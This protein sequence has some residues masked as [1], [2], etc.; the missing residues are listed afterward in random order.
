MP[1]TLLSTRIRSSVC[2]RSAASCPLTAPGEEVA[3]ALGVTDGVAVAVTVGEAVAEVVGTSVGVTLGVGWAVGPGEGVG[4]TSVVVGC[5]VA[6]APASAITASSTSQRRR[7]TGSR[8]YTDQAM[9]VTRVAAFVLG[10][11]LMACNAPVGTTQR[12]IEAQPTTAAVSD[13]APTPMRAE[14]LCVDGTVHMPDAPT[15]LPV[16]NLVEAEAVLLAEVARMTGVDKAALLPSNFGLEE[17]DIWGPGVAWNTE[18]VGVQGLQE[19][20]QFYIDLYSGQVLS[21]IDYQSCW[22]GLLALGGPFEIVTPAPSFS[23]GPG[24]LGVAPDKPYVDTPIDPVYAGDNFRPPEDPPFDEP[25]LADIYARVSPLITTVNGLPYVEIRSDFYCSEVDCH[26]QLLAWL[27]NAADPDEWWIGIGRDGSKNEL[28]RNDVWP[29]QYR[30]V[31]HDAAEELLQIVAS[32]P[33]AVALAG[34]YTGFAFASWYPNQLGLMSVSYYRP[35]GL[36][37]GPPI[38]N[39]TTHYL[40]IKIDIVEKH[41]IGF[42]EE[43]RDG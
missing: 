8:R 6:Q 7:I 14:G 19:Q 26:L 13:P 24:L 3:V 10:A 9:P 39:A 20:V 41:V 12:S 15:A 4:R 5:G 34:E 27:R 31:P 11:M 36:I 32:D 22:D 43:V 37:T 42:V 21:A 2:W 17:T 23:P 28:D 16:L 38:A 29:S 25:T 35:G 33:A 30:S 18:K 1:G 40:T